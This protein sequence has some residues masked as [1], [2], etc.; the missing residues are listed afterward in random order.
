MTAEGSVYQRKSDRRWVAQYT[1]LVHV[2]NNQ[3]LYIEYISV[4]ENLLNARARTLHA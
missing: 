2:S 3:G 4:R 1:N